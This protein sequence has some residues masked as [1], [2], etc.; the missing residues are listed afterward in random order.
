MDE[1]EARVHKVRRRKAR[2]SIS[3][4]S[5]DMGLNESTKSSIIVIPDIVSVQG[6][7]KVR[8]GERSREPALK[9]KGESEKV[10]SATPFDPVGFIDVE[11]EIR[12]PVNLCERDNLE[13]DAAGS[14]DNRR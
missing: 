9:T 14:K 10:K 8:T 13:F 4:G 12:G 2:D 11:D 6:G 1:L 5:R 3:V 7:R